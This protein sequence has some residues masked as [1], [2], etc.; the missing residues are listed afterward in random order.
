MTPVK[1][2][3]RSLTGIAVGFGAECA[4]FIKLSFIVGSKAAFFSAG[5]CVSPLVGL[6]SGVGMSVIALC[7]RSSLT[8]Y[9]LHMTP[10]LA[11][12]YHIPTFFAALYLATIAQPKVNFLQRAGM[13]LLIV[14]CFAAFGLHSVGSQAVAYTAFWLIPLLSTLI[15]HNNRFFHA[16]ASTF[17]AHAVGSVIWLYSV[18]PV[19]PAAWLALMPVV[20][21][22]RLLFASGMTLCML[23]VAAG[24]KLVAKRAALLETAPHI[25]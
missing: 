3:S 22:E 23:A 1:N 11:L 7:I 6:Y 13:A 14:A 15:A 5:H 20:V 17:T 8:S 25:S 12:A 9:T 18:G 19:S 10:H 2:F 16:L 24:K 21:V 4:R